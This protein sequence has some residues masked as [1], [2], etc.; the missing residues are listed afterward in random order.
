MPAPESQTL[1]QLQDFITDEITTNNAGDITGA[2]VREILL[3]LTVNYPHVEEQLIT[4]A[5]AEAG[6]A[7]SVRLYT[8]QL[9]STAVNRTARRIID[10]DGDTYFHVEASTD[11]DR[12]VG[13]ASGLQMFSLSRTGGTGQPSGQIGDAASGPAYTLSQG[14]MEIKPRSVAVLQ[15][16]DNNPGLQVYIGDILQAVNQTRLSVDDSTSTIEA[17]ASNVVLGSPVGFGNATR[18]VID[19]SAQSVEFFS[20]VI[21]GGLTQDNTQERLLSVDPVTNQLFWRS[22][23][24][25]SG[26][27]GSGISIQD[28]DGD[29]YITTDDALGDSDA[30][31]MYAQNQQIFSASV[32]VSNN[33]RII[34]GNPV[35]QVGSARLDIDDDS[36]TAQLI[37]GTVQI[38]GPSQQIEVVTSANAVY[39]NQ[40][41]YLQQSA[42]STARLRLEDDQISALGIDQDNTVT[43]ILGL[44]SAGVIQWRDASTLGG[45]GGAS[46]F[47]DLSDVDLTTA[48][49][50][51]G[52]FITYDGSNWVPQTPV[53]V[54]D[55]SNLTAGDQTNLT[56]GGNY[57]ADNEYTGPAIVG[58]IDEGVEWWPASSDFFYKLV[59]STWH[60]I[61]K[62]SA[63]GGTPTELVDGAGTVSFDSEAWVLQSLNNSC[64]LVYGAW[65]NAG[66]VEG[67]FTVGWTGS[68]AALDLQYVEGDPAS[69]VFSTNVRTNVSSLSI[70][71][72]TDATDDGDTAKAVFVSG[73]GSNHIF[74]YGDIVLT[75]LGSGVADVDLTTA[76]PTD[77][78][79]L[80]W[81]AGT[82]TWVPTTVSGGGGAS[83]LD[84]LTDVY[85]STASS[86]TLI[87]DSS[88]NGP[89]LV[90]TDGK[91]R[92]LIIGEFAGRNIRTNISLNAE[93]NTV[94]IGPFA[95]DGIDDA[96]R[97]TVIGGGAGLNSNG[98][99]N[100]MV[101]WEAGS[102]V[103]GSDNILIGGRAGRN[104]TLSNTLVLRGSGVDFLRIQP[105]ASPVIVQIPALPAY[106]DQAAAGAALATNQLFY[107]STTG[108]VDQVR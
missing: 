76:A 33:L 26:G 78:Q 9:L 87:G 74:Q 8:P 46:A 102:G 14:L 57:N 52:D 77:G 7:T 23:S 66:T 10:T 70:Q 83:A 40:F 44:T 31:G 17:K 96:Y 5:E 84:D 80:T 86:V 108:G 37:G 42:A 25:I 81:S 20:D 94:L 49:P 21:I 104:E 38:G 91:S 55:T 68:L 105:S 62:L 11:S 47:G 97:C 45:G 15:A 75:T 82:S 65:D 18:I 12:L 22:A 41:E 54:F 43:E 60:R 13:F 107:N 64:R 89:G 35:S 67:Y 34:I 88:A 63:A 92:I 29:T 56:T 73:S 28:A 24:S 98:D 50:V 27:G 85:L 6:T 53:D 95:G 79:V 58:Q 72:M 30:I 51:S 1:Q 106:A 3:N 19:D 103:T 100:I 93:M 90:D 2:D 69:S 32:D 59:G 39:F 48:A 36:D 61:S 99:T 4:T 101:G 16:R 71:S